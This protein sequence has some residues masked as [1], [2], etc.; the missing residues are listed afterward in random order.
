MQG[1]AR[2]S[3]FPAEPAAGVPRYSVV[4]PTYQRRELVVASVRALAAV[5]HEAG[6][7]VTV[8]VDGSTDGTAEL[9]RC[10]DVPFPLTVVEQPNSGAARARNE[11]A[12][13]SIGQVLLFLDD[14]MQAAPDLL[15]AHDEAY[16][17]GADAV[18]G[19]VPL[20]PDAPRTFLSRGTQDWADGRAR[21]LAAAPA[22]T[23]GDLLTGQLSIR[24]ELFEALGGFDEAFTRDGSFG[25]ED[26][27]FGRRLLEAGHRLVFAPGA[28]SWQ[29][30]A[31]SPSAYLRQWHQAGQ[32][33]VA[34]LRKHPAEAEAVQQARRPTERWNRRVWRPL[35][36]APRLSG[37][38]AWVGRRAV[39][40][41]AER[42]PDAAATTRWFFRIRNL[43]YWRGVHEAGGLPGRHP[44]RVLCYHAV[45][46]LAGAPVLAQY[47]V[48]ADL[49]RRQL[50]RLQRMGFRFVSGEEVLRFVERGAGLPRRP[51]LLTFDD[52]YTDL[53]GQAVPVLRDLRVPAVA[54]AVSGLTG[55]TNEWDARHG[56]PTL[57]LLDGAGLRALAEAG[58]EVGAHG[59]THCSL[60]GLPEDRL[61]AETRGAAAELVSL[62]LPQP[63]MFSYPYG[64]HDRAARVAV[65]GSGMRLAF[66]VAPGLVRP[67]AL[68][69]YELPRVEVLRADGAGVRL[70]AKVALARRLPERVRRPL[71]R[72]RRRWAAGR[73]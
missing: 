55:G 13:R 8:V 65:A 66:T 57:R 21:R 9:L 6:L 40:G 16:A 58:V 23:T 47:G 28:V 30:Y 15:R 12:R 63:R 67:E 5:D 60:A 45:S 17:E 70:V 7:E 26:T 69:R 46:D 59:S 72:A 54:F 56:A 41:L 39:L 38:V 36:H 50:V 44:L 18:V 42:R 20:H 3:A 62:G 43:E 53:L 14:D 10:L 34:Y 1:S 32:A 48:P 27:D 64:E 37:V 61:A 11:G 51:V 25:R 35:S 49:L 68:E 22:L 33:D 29:Y 19:H 2:G 24:R 31:V 52:C 71:Q 4:I 73:G